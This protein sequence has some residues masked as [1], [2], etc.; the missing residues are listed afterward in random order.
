[1]FNQT[2]EPAPGAYPDFDPRLSPLSVALMERRLGELNRL[3]EMA[4]GRLRHLQETL[5]GE[6]GEADRKL[7]IGRGGVGMEFARLSR[8]LRQIVVLEMEILGLRD[9]P[10]RA[11]PDDDGEAEK[12]A[13]RPERSDLSDRADGGDRVETDGQLLA[14]LND[15]RKAPLDIVV[16][17]IRETL[18]AEPPEDDPFAPPP[19]RR[20]AKPRA[21]G[22]K[23]VKPAAP[24]KTAETARTARAASA[25]VVH[26]GPAILAAPAGPR[27]AI[28]DLLSGTARNRGP[29]W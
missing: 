29:P 26:P 12:D 15:Y 3:S 19:G 18:G 9:A 20:P 25:G 27:R 17:E 2:P 14:D 4:V 23:I 24:V 11:E 22:R 1:M 28:R 5:E 13:E 7:L 10:E 16:A 6:V 8:S 21:T